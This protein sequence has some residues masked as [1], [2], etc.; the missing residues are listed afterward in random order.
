MKGE[1][2]AQEQECRCERPNVLVKGAGVGASENQSNAGSVKSHAVDPYG[3]LHHTKPD[4]RRS[5][6]S[7]A[8]VTMRSAVGHG[9]GSQAHGSRSKGASR[10][11]NHFGVI[12]ESVVK[13][14]RRVCGDGAID[15]MLN[16]AIVATYGATFWLF[17]S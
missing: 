2:T 6:P 1:P 10:S 15:G 14:S 16:P 8:S 13:P 11:I 3:G 17:F 4:Q 7:S 5:K 9:C 12:H